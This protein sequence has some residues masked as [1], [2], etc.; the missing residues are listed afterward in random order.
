LTHERMEGS[1]N[2]KQGRPGSPDLTQ[3]S[4]GPPVP[5]RPCN[6]GPPAQ[7]G[8]RALL[9]PKCVEEVTRE[10]GN[11]KP[12][13]STKRMA[14]PQIG[15][16]ETPKENAEGLSTGTRRFNNNGGCAPPWDRVEARRP[17]ELSQQCDSAERGRPNVDKVGPNSRV[18][19]RPRFSALRWATEWAAC[20]TSPPARALILKAPPSLQ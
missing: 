9:S 20:N 14:C 16:A 3:V 6:S 5:C 19:S 8:P 11:E 1:A 17:V 15:N 2:L 4:R 10:W 12:C 7:G 18:V 13:H